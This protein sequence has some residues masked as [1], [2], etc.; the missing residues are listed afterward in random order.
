MNKKN[1]QNT[2]LYWLEEASAEGYYSESELIAYNIDPIWV[3]TDQA[4]GQERPS[5]KHI[6]EA[7]LSLG[8]SPVDI[9]CR[10][11]PDILDD[12]AGS[13][14]S[15][16]LELMEW[17]VYSNHHE[18]S[19]ILGAYAAHQRHIHGCYNPTYDIPANDNKKVPLR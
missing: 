4:T 15:F 13:P 16:L 8:I 7:A 12:S 6:E 14:H 5:L 10:V 9:L 11:I 2:F 3:T 18:T 19:R 17:I 1:Q